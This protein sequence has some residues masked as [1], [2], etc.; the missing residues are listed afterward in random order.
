MYEI[1]MAF[2]YAPEFWA[3]IPDYKGLYQVSNL[4]RVRSLNRKIKEANSKRVQSKPGQILKPWSAGKN[5]RLKVSLRKE[6][7][8]WAVPTYKLVA[9]A[10][11]GQSNLTIDHINGDYL[12]NNLANLRYITR[13]EN[14]RLGSA[15]LT[16][17]QVRKIKT[18]LRNRL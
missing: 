10:F 18:L 5:G 9:L 13:A 15:I 3:D 14:A 11:L 8:R 1:Q 7:K 2:R 6:A 16:E 4:G 12:D 17:E